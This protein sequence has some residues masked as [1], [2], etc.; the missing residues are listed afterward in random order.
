MIGGLRQRLVVEAPNPSDDG[1]GGQTDPWQSPLVVATVW[2][3]VEPLRGVERQEAG[4]LEARHSHRIR[5]RHRD[6]VGTGQRIRLG[7]RLFNIRAV[8]DLDV[9]GQWLILHCEEGVAT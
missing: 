9:R 7:S 2:G 3:R 6:D 1:H 5:I 4:R 8:T